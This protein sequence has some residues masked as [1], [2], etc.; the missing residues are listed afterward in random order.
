MSFKTVF[1]E[2]SIAD[3]EVTKDVLHRL[4][5]AKHIV[6]HGR[7]FHKIIVKEMM[8]IGLPERRHTL[9]DEEYEN[10]A[11][12]QLVP[13]FPEEAVRFVSRVGTTK[14]GILKRGETCALA[15]KY[16]FLTYGNRETMVKPSMRSNNPGE[17]V[18]CCDYIQLNPISSCPYQCMYCYESDL[19][20]YDLPFMRLYV[21]YKEM[22]SVLKEIDNGVLPRNFPK[23]SEKCWRS[24]NMGEHADSLAQESIFRILPE[25]V[26][27]FRDFKNLHL[28]LLSKGGNPELLPDNPPEGK[29]AV[30]FSI[31]TRAVSQALE[32]GTPDPEERLKTLEKAYQKGYRVAIRLDPLVPW[33][34]NWKENLENLI[35]IID[36]EAPQELSEITIG[37]MRFRKF[38]SSLFCQ[39][40]K[41]DRVK[42]PQGDLY[43]DSV[44]HKAIEFLYSKDAQARLEKGF[45][46]NYYRFP[47]EERKELYSHAVSLIKERRPELRV[48]LCQKEDKMYEE[49]DGVNTP[50]KCNCMV[51]NW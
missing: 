31:N 41:S 30:A 6:V 7:T 42:T 27:W 36:K 10:E 14:A 3:S 29:I 25:I 40:F 24:V 4:P 44:N 49:V 46:D 21:N 37:M 47:F 8:K 23:S 51:A 39:M 50:S 5:D 19:R 43:S 1:I 22:L 13:R 16:L 34:H 17:K 15:K 35:E 11:V 9:S 20:G 48:T 18:L 28:L 32:V 26:G 33:P 38:Q 12:K 2:N 45:S